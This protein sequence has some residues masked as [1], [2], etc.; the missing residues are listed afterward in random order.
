MYGDEREQIRV[1]GT[2]EITIHF[3]N[4]TE[5]VIF[6]RTAEKWRDVNQPVIKC[7]RGHGNIMNRK[8]RD[9]AHKRRRRTV[10]P[11]ERMSLFPHT[12]LSRGTYD[13]LPG[14]RRT[15]YVHTLITF[16]AN[17]IATV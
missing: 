1:H 5:I 9:R 11:F 8:C 10:I 3:V 17:T 6:A 13:A 7:F 15:V 2:L 14:R 16:N 12:V 4:R